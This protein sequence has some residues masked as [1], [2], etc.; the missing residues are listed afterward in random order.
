MAQVVKKKGLLNATKKSGGQA[1]EGHAYLKNWIWWLGM[2]M[3]ILGEICNFAAFGELWKDSCLV[4]MRGEGMMRLMRYRLGVVS[5]H[6]RYLGH[7]TWSTQ[8]GESLYWG[9]NLHPSA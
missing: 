2:T 9:L 5:V 3:M 1:G 6:G 7:T 8:C 4:L